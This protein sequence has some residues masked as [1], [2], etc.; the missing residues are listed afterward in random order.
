VSGS[1]QKSGGSAISRMRTAE[2]KEY[3]P[4]EGRTVAYHVEGNGRPTGYFRFVDGEGNQ[5]GEADYQ[6]REDLGGCP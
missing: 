3:V 6:G 1:G 4:T 2:K 5:Q